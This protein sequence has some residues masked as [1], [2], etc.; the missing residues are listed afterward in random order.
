MTKDY[1]SFS[2]I[3][4]INGGDVT[5]GDTLKGKIIRVDNIGG[6]SSLSIELFFLLIV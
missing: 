1:S 4:I 2:S 5:F 6:K 3:T